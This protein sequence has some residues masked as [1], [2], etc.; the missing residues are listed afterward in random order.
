M[1]VAHQYGPFV[2]MLCP[3]QGGKRTVHEVV[4]GQDAGEDT[5]V[6]TVE[7]TTNASETGD[8]ED[9][10]V[11]DQGHG[12]GVAHQRLAAIE[13][14]IEGGGGGCDGHGGGR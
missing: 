14:D 11:L 7:Q 9:A 13:G 8:A 12:T 5:L 4:H 3:R 10:D 2:Y 1:S 6:V